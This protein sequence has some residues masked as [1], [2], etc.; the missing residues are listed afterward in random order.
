MDFKGARPF[1]Y[2]TLSNLK[3]SYI[4][5]G[6]ST[7]GGRAADGAACHF[8]FTAY[9]KT[10][11]GC[12]S[13]IMDRSISRKYAIH[14]WNLIEFCKLFN[15]V[16]SI[17]LSQIS[18]ISAPVGTRLKSDGYSLYD[19]DWCSMTAEYQPGGSWGKCTQGEP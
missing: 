15:E 17:F 13:K 14:I 10:H 16:M 5:D 9:G 8:P 12:R 7:I 3:Q 4:L 1:L 19:F 11:Y 2:D 18:D 6:S